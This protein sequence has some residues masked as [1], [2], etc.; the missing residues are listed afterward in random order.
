LYIY[1]LDTDIKTIDL[2]QITDIARKAGAQIL[3][4]Y[5]CATTNFEIKLDQSPCT[6]AD[7]VSH[8]VISQ[9]LTEIFPDLPVISEEEDTSNWNQNHKPYWLIDPLDGTKEF[10]E[11]NGEFTVNIALIENGNPVL[12]V[13]YVPVFDVMYFASQK[14]GAYKQVAHGSAHQLKIV[15][16]YKDIF[17]V[18]VSRRHDLAPLEKFISNV[19]NCKII[20]MGSSLKICAIAE[21][22]VDIYP[23]FGPT[24]EW[25]T[26]A[27]QCVLEQAGGRMID[28]NLQKLTYNKSS[29]KNPN[30]LAIGNGELSWAQY[31]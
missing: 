29:L 23:R 20:S 17:N 15:P 11:K 10:L 4:I 27:A 31:L 19:G 18:A 2:G 3:E 14:D 26:A 30:F 1:K 5:Q 28:K 25:D 8:Q 7:K 13:V 9:S 16:C 24:M 21:G 22:V 6:E 12:G